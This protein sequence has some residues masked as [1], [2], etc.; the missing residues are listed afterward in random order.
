MSPFFNC[1]ECG[2]SLQFDGECGE[3][4]NGEYPLCIICGEPEPCPCDAFDNYFYEQ[5]MRGAVREFRADSP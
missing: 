4:I 1:E 3:C 2:N 5:T